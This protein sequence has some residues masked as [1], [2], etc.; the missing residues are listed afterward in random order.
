MKIGASLITARQRLR[1]WQDTEADRSFFHRVNSEEEMLKFFPF[2]R[3][4]AEADEVFDRLR[5]QAES[6]GLGWV[7]AEDRSSGKPI[8]FTGLAK[9]RDEDEQA[10]CPGVEIGWRYVP[11]AWGK[12][13]ASEAARA[14]LAH[15]FD[16]IGLDHISAFAVTSNQPSIA[17]M[18]RIGMSARPD[19]DFD[20]PGVPDD[21]PHL[22][23]HVIYQMRATDP[24]P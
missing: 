8:G 21:M 16:E 17:V 18:R 20:H 5:A 22:K 3:S 7:L 24:R 19:L 2:R 12:G 4:R 13:L 9:I 10:I 15:G 6:N 1:H 14:L 23:R 11:E